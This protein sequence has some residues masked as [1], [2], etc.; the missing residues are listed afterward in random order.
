MCGGRVAC[1]GDEFDTLPVSRDQP[2]VSKSRFSDRDLGIPLKGREEG[3][4]E[5]TYTYS[6]SDMLIDTV[7]V[8]F[9][10]GSTQAISRTHASSETP[11]ICHQLYRISIDRAE[12][13]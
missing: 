4:E 6:E 13:I 5:K 12:S 11:S 2:F 1:V 3:R 7:L 9:A 8:I 10:I